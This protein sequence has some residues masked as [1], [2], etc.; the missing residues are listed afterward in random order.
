MPRSRTFTRP[1]RKIDF[2]QWGAIPGLITSGSGDA[3]LG[4]GGL[5]FAVPATILRFRGYWA[6]MFDETAQANDQMNITF[7]LAIVSTDAFTLGSTALPD[8]ADEPEFPWIWWGDMRLDSF[9]VLTD[10]RTGWGPAAQRQEI[11]SKAMRKIKPGETVTYV[12]QRSNASGAPVTLTDV[13]Q[14]RVLI[15][16]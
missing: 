15:G 10:T 12:L 6:N 1:A 14:I 11:D 4:G 9:G 8:P 2:K 7:G 16:T 13:G 5:S 3:T